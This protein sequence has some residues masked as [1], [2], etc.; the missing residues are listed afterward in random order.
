MSEWVTWPENKPK[1]KSGFWRVKF[2]DGTE[3]ICELLP[4][5]R[6]NT[7]E[8]VIAWA[9]LVTGFEGHNKEQKK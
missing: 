3:G 4:S 7:P 9:P 2:E 5:W 8:K 6:W 1:Y